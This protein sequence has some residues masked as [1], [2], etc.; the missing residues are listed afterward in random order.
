M[1]A[2]GAWR[3]YFT[4]YRGWAPF[5]E[6]KKPGPTVKTFPDRESAL[7]FRAT[8]PKDENFIVTMTAAPP[9]RAKLTVDPK[10]VQGEEWLG[11]SMKSPD[12]KLT[13]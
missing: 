13:R 10:D 6:M 7:A 4:D 3:V 8:L 5:G 9:P 12:R 2:T 1:T 11:G